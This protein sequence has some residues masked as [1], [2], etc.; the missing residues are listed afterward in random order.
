MQK[1]NNKVRG[2]NRIIVGILFTTIV[3][4]SFLGSPFFWSTIGYVVILSGL[5]V[6]KEYGS[7]FHKAMP[8]VILSLL[9]CYL[10]LYPMKINV[11]DIPQWFY[12]YVP[13]SR[14]AFF[15]IRIVLHYYII[16]GIQEISV[17][18]DNN[19]FSHWTRII[20]FA[21][22]TSNFV[23]SVVSSLILLSTGTQLV[24]PTIR[25]WLTICS[26]IILSVSQIAYL[27]F[28]KKICSLFKLVL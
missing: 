6:L 21:L 7:L 17:N 12:L 9:L 2:V 1:K 16:F 3:F 26:I 24:T 20:Y 5:N 18:I 25:T 14:G 19:S 13:L 4:S 10:E 11:E 15:A 23:Q 28:L 22:F 8:F 27:V